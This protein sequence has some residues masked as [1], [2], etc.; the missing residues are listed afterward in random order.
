MRERHPPLDVGRL[1][2]D[3]H[4]ASRVNRWG[5]GRQEREIN[6][7]PPNE[8]VGDP[9]SRG[10]GRTAIE[11]EHGEGQPLKGIRILEAQGSMP[12]L[13]VIKDLNILK[14]VR[15]GFCPGA[16]DAPMHPLPFEVAKKLSA[17]ALS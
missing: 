6:Q 4:P 8:G 7:P 14:E 17:M 2:H 13:P 12:P 5:D 15:R 10:R 1:S 11:P 16:I 9:R 3:A